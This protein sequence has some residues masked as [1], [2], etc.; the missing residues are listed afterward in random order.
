LDLCTP[1][2]ASIPIEERDPAEVT[3]IGGRRLAPEGVSAW[4]PAFD[5][6]PA[7]LITAIITDKGIIRPSELSVSPLTA[8][9]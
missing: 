2:G 4:N 7:E 3:G 8:H 5:V 1:D 9:L 6:T